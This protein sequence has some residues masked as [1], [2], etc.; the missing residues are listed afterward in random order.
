MNIKRIVV[1]SLDTNCYIVENE[2]DCLIIDPGDEFHK[3][4]DNITKKVVGVLVTHRH[5]DHVGVLEEILKFYNV[6]CYDKSNLINGEN[7]ISSFKFNV[8]YNPGHTF[9]S[10]SFIFDNNMF[11]GDFI[12]QGT[13]G[14]CDLGG[15]INL[16]KDSINDILN[17]EI[18]YIIYPGHG[19][20]TT[21]NE[22]RVNLDY[23]LK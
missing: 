2:L 19:E 5:F 17:S 11:S 13:I 23:W 20:C 14:R 12:F 22:E 4:R 8:I 1:G 7:N 10:I 16:M 3:I 9:D 21:L 18:N 6:K 15:D